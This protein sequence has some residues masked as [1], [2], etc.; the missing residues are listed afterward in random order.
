MA[1][2]LKDVV[3]QYN[4]QAGYTPPQEPGNFGAPPPE[5]TSMD[6][7]INNMANADKLTKAEKKIYKALPGVTTWMDNHTIRGK[8]YSEQLENLNEGWA[9]KALQKLDFLAE[10]LE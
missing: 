7:Q 1:R 4:Q 2:T 8:T 9:G 10:G 6:D 3:S 5:P